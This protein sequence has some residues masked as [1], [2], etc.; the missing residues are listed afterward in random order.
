M[1]KV[2][3]A[4]FAALALLPA[5]LRAQISNIVVTNAASFQPGIP[6]PGSIG[7]IFCT[8]LSVTGIVSAPGVPPPFSLSDVTVTV[9]G[10]PAP[11]FA[12][13]ALG[14]YQQIN[15]Q[16]PHET[17]VN[18]GTTGDTA[19][20]AISQNGVQGKAT[21]NLAPQLGDFFRVGTTQYGIFQHSADYSLVTTTNPAKRGE[22]IVAYATGLEPPVPSVPIGQPTPLSPLYYVPQTRALPVIDLTGVFIRDGVGNP[23]SV[24][25]L[26]GGAYDPNGN[27]PFMGLTPGAIGLYQINFVVPA[28][29]S[30]GNASVNLRHLACNPAASPFGDCQA[31]GATVSTD[32]QAVLLPVQ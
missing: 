11:L 15:F 16:V 5:I 20:V 19:E 8:G 18:V 17:Q 9:G 4:S 10:S 31:P 23:F 27:L 26:A 28:G 22:T 7:T 25:N 21:A 2:A 1:K 32:S 3:V 14:G 13:A 12:V 24:F 6:A 30:S 29:I